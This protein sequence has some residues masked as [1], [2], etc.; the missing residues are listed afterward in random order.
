MLDFLK[1]HV[2]KAAD[3]PPLAEGGGNSDSDGDAK[4]KRVRKPRCAARRAHARCA[5]LWARVVCAH[6]AHCRHAAQGTEAQG[7]GGERRQRR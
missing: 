5:A 7:C 6:A 4:P 3:L 1:D 2:A